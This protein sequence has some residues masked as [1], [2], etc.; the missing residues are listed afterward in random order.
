MVRPHPPHQRRS[1]LPHPRRIALRHHRSLTRCLPDR[2]AARAGRRVITSPRHGTGYHLF[3]RLQ[4]V[5]LRGFQS[6]RETQVLDLDSHLTFLAGLNDVGKS[7]LLRALRMMVDQQQGFEDDFAITFSWRGPSDE[8]TSI[9]SEEQG[10]ENLINELQRTPEQTFVAQFNRAGE[11]EFHCNELALPNAGMSTGP[12]RPNVQAGW[13]SGPFAKNVLGIKRLIELSQRQLRQVKFIT[14]R[15]VELGERSLL[16]QTQIDADGRNLTD[17][18]LYMRNNEIERFAQLEQFITDAF[19]NIRSIT[20][21]QNSQQSQIT[22]EPALIYRDRQQP[23][24]LRLCGSGIEQMLVLGISVL[25]AGAETLLLIDEPQA[26][27]HPHAERSLLT[28]LDLHPEHQYVIATHSHQLL[29]SKPLRQARLISS[30]NG[31]SSIGSPTESAAVLE[32][33]GVTAADLWLADT[34]LWVEGASEEAAFEQLIAMLPN[35]D[36][37]KAIEIRGMPGDAS[38]FA[39]RNEKQAIAAYRFCEQVSKAISPLPVTMRFLFDTDEKPPEFRQTMQERS[40]SRAIFLPCRELE[41]LFLNPV[42]IASAL[43]ERCSQVGQSPPSHDEIARYLQDKLAEADNQDL[44]P[45]SN[46]LERAE[47]DRVRGSRVLKA[48]YWKFS[49]SEYDK[50]KDAPTLVRH[51][52]SADS[53]ALQPLVDILEALKSGDNSAQVNLH[54]PSAPVA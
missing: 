23:I 18:L 6:Y 15:R 42:A 14:P 52:H 21:R 17:V 5:E 29:R 45:E 12:M 4:R 10:S 44:L 7:A 20:V 41:N 46:D 47:R 24:P 35:R 3:V 13:A 32:S 36:E 49:T 19:P 43:E 22:G 34:V 40:N 30:Q 16:T 38:R 39:G 37:Y 48:I 50:V 51:T 33:L 11:A 25:T 1:D 9:L 31:S 8:L 28:L 54:T 2:R 53:T 27:L 26:Y